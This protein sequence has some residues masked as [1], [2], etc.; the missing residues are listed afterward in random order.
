MELTT[1]ERRVRTLVREGF[2]SLKSRKKVGEKSME[3]RVFGPV[4]RIKDFGD[5]G[6]KRYE[7][8]TEDLPSSD[9]CADMEGRE[10]EGRESGGDEVEKG[11]KWGYGRRRWCCGGSD[12]L[13]ML[14]LGFGGYNQYEFAECIREKER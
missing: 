2:E 14:H 5:R 10:K 7:F 3:K 1:G 12:G 11:L 9:K 8:G 13:V 6:L 4:R